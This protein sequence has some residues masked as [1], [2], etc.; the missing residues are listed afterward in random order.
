MSWHSIKLLTTNKWIIEFES[1]CKD[2]ELN[3]FFIDYMNL[4]NL[5]TSPI[6]IIFDMQ[7]LIVPSISQLTKQIIFIQKMKTL[8]KEKLQYFFLIINT[9]IVQ[10]LVDW[11]FKITPPVVPYKIVNCLEE[12]I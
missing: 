9:K 12:I 11:V 6:I 3:Q 2:H 5:S 4:L 8:H 7:K 10:D 1:H